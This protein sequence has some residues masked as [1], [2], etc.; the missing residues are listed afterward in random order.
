MTSQEAIQ[1]LHQ[2]IDEQQEYDRKEIFRN[3]EQDHK[4]ADNILCQIIIEYVEDGNKI[5]EEYGKIGK[6]YA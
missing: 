4:E 1:K 5:V 3:L 2:I 6:W